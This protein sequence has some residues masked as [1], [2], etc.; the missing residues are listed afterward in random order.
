MAVVEQVVFDVVIWLVETTIGK[1]YAWLV[2]PHINTLATAPYTLTSPQTGS[3][4][5]N[6]H[7]YQHHIWRREPLWPRVERQYWS[8][9][10]TTGLEQ[11][12]PG[13]WVDDDGF[14]L[15]GEAEPGCVQIS[16][17]TRLPIHG[18]TLQTNVETWG[19]FTG[20]APYAIQAVNIEFTYRVVATVNT[21]GI[22]F[23]PTLYELRD[24]IG[25]EIAIIGQDGWDGNSQTWQLFQQGADV[26]VPDDKRSSTLPIFFSIDIYAWAQAPGVLQSF[27][28]RL[29]SVRIKMIPLYGPIDLWDPRQPCPY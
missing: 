8:N 22:L 18:R 17:G 2:G 11:M 15:A 29:D 21:A 23:Q 16:A 27:T 26:E 24:G 6:P 4:L 25:Y 20:S 1:A 19:Y 14:S 10:F 5:S 7:P 28:V 13:T 9:N 12:G 3:M